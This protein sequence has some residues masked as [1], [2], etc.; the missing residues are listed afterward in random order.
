MGTGK[1]TVGPLLA[2]RLGVNFVDLDEA[3]ESAER[4]S[5]PEIFQRTGEA[6]FRRAEAAALEQ[7]SSSQPIVLALGGGTLHQAG[8]RE[9][10]EGFRIFVLHA[11]WSVLSDRLRTDQGQRPLWDQAEGLY[12]QRAAGY[13]AAG[14]C[15]SVDD[16]TPEEVVEAIMAA[17]HED[18]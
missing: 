8:W 10:L 7:L 11:S 5:I 4:C 13:T 2:R 12:Q 17:L 14:A 1:S 18:E 3:I 6:G 15:I 9:R 16:R